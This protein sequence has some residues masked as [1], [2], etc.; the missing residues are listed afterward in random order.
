MNSSEEPESI[1]QVGDWVW[2]QYT[3]QDDEVDENLALVVAILHYTDQHT[4]V[5]VLWGKIVQDKSPQHVV[6]TNECRAVDIGCIGSKVVEPESGGRVKTENSV[7]GELSLDRYQIY[8]DS[9]KRLAV[10]EL[11]TPNTRSTY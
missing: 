5:A 7:G 11:S 8:L 2:V 3:T 9:R 10:S 1:I 6:C 4:D